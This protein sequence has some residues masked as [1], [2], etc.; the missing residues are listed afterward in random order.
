MSKDKIIAMSEKLNKLGF[1]V[2]PKEQWDLMIKKVQTPP[3]TGLRIS[4]V[5]GDTSITSDSKFEYN[6]AEHRFTSPSR[7]TE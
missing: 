1:V 6:K 7:S 5:D 2:V 3:P 4:S